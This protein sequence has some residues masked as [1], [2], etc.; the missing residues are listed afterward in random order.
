V[1]LKAAFAWIKSQFSLLFPLV[2]SPA[3]LKKT[4][5]RSKGVTASRIV[6]SLTRSFSPPLREHELDYSNPHNPEYIG[7]YN[8]HRV[9]EHCS[10][11]GNFI[12]QFLSIYPLG[13]MFFHEETGIP[14]ELGT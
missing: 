5:S 12:I 14:S 9:F 10:N 13:H 2:N 11:L 6:K 7:Q 1:F 3:L 8:P 4:S